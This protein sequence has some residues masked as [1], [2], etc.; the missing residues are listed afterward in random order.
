MSKT[1]I[2]PLDI[3]LGQ[4]SVH[5]IELPNFC[6]WC[7]THIN[8]E[9]N[10]RSQLDL[11]NNPDLPF[12]LILQCPVCHKH[13]IQSYE[14]DYDSRYTSVR[15]LI[16]NKN[17]PMPESTFDYP[18]NINSISKEFQNIISQSSQAESLGYNHLAGIGYRKA[19]EFLVKDYLINF[20][21]LNKEEISKKPLGQCISEIEDIRIQN[22]AKAA[23]WIGNDETHYVRK[24]GDKDLADLKIFLHAFVSLVN[25]DLNVKNATNLINNH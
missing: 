3:N 7:H 14:V 24:H 10:G 16:L 9:I 22:L 17:K 1:T 18:E 25:L 4:T 13:F 21:N 11:K 15:D 19:L 5:S 20:K 8:P 12:S 23:T 2:V 6:P